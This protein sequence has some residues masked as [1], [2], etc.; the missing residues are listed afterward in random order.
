M[1]KLIR[2]ATLASISIVG[3]V[4][5]AC[6]AKIDT[7]QLS[8]E[9]QFSAV[10]QQY[11]AVAEYLTETRSFFEDEA[12]IQPLDG[13]IP[14]LVVPTPE[15]AAHLREGIALSECLRGPSGQ[16][17]RIECDFDTDCNQVCEGKQDVQLAICLAICRH[18]VQR[19]CRVILY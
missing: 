11:P 8:A 12:K 6:Q 18:R 17:I 10:E 7:T 3:L 13:H 2:I 5:G 1:S 4:L 15:L 16:C 9:E 14:G 19:S